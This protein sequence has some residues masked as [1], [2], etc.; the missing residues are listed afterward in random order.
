MAGGALI[1]CIYI[2]HKSV[3]DVLVRLKQ[4]WQLGQSKL[5]QLKAFLQFEISQS[6]HCSLCSPKPAAADKACHCFLA[7][8]SRFCNGPYFRF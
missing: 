7:D 8:Y 2:D 1:Y 6:H 3:S 5:G 4:Y